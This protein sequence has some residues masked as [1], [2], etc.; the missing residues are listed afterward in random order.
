M[1]AIDHPAAADRRIPLGGPDALSWRDVVGVYERVLGRPVAV[2]WIARGEL[3][4]DLPPVPGLTELVSGLLA[5]LE[6][7]DSPVDMTETART[8]GLAP[9]SAEDFVRRS[10]ADGPP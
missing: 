1:A 6:T 3:L 4:P 8:Y 2:R 10:F 7:F 5:G 9:T